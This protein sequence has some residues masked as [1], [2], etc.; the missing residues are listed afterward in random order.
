[1]GEILV[2]IE[3]GT[4][5]LTYVWEK[6]GTVFTP[7]DD[8]HLTDLGVGTYTVTI[9]DSNQPTNCVVT[10]TLEV[11]QPSALT[12]ASAKHDIF[13]TDGVSEPRDAKKAKGLIEVTVE[14]GTPDYN[15]TWS[16]PG[17]FTSSESDAKGLEIGTYTVTV[18]DAN[19]C[20]ISE[21]VQIGRSDAFDV[22]VT[23]FDSDALT[24]CQLD[25]AKLNYEVTGAADSLIWQ[26]TDMVNNTGST[27]R[28]NYDDTKSDTTVYPM[29]QTKYKLVARNEYCENKN[30]EITINVNPTPI[31]RI[32]KDSMIVKEALGETTLL[33]EL[34]ND[35]PE[36]VVYQWIPSDGL[37]TPDAL[38]TQANVTQ[39][40][41]YKF[42]ATSDQGCSYSD[43]IF[44]LLV[45]NVEPYSGFSPNG[46][47][48][49]D[50]W[51]I[52]NASAYEN[53]IVQ[54]FSR[55]GKKVFE[56]KRYDSD[57]ADRRWDGTSS[58]GNPLPSGTYY[59]IIDV[60]EPGVSPLTGPITIVR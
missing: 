26:Y 35:E 28:T 3:N 29:Y 22:E 54:V 12:I 53:I 2:T 48:I 33:A 15:Y 47:G 51:T 46:D 18:L 60:R 4:D 58:A 49:N 13:C 5:P 25:G 8:E 50:F 43:S 7:A 17:G 38:S 56:Q 31:V 9:T 40:Q 21:N 42:I 1:N 44:V 6:D 45:P 59:Y 55:W 32:E 16:G 34:I 36:S 14:G 19:G 10:E 27:K 23:E 24:I 37:A 57:D 20:T 41:Y 11:T 52:E 30:A 39:T